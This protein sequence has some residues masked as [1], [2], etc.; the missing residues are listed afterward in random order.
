MHKIYFF[1]YLLFFSLFAFGQ[2]NIGNGRGAGNLWVGNHSEKTFEKLK[3]TSTNFVLPDICN[4]NELKDIIESVWT[5]N[6]ISFITFDELK[7]N[8][9]KY[10]S[11]DQINIYIINTDYTVSKGIETVGYFNKFVFYVFAYKNVHTTKKGE[12]DYDHMDMAE[13]YLSRDMLYAEDQ[14]DTYCLRLGLIKNYFQ[15]LNR[16]LT[17]SQNLKMNDGIV[18]EDKLASLATE[19]LH[20]PWAVGSDI[21][22]KNRENIQKQ[23]DKVLNAYEHPYKLISYEELNHKILNNEDFI[24]LNENQFSKFKIL[25]IAKSLDGEMIYLNVESKYRVKPSDMGKISKIISKSL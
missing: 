8:K 11:S 1:T 13:I 14:E 19:T 18:K 24:Y 15:E 4:K 9:E 6:P 21:P 5:F 2:V 16:R 17:N 20:I 3:T 12:F 22:D 23:L 10:I 7:S 25:T